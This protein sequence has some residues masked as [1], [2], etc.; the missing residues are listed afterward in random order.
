MA[1]RPGN[2]EGGDV[3]GADVVEVAG[4]TER[5]GGL[6]PTMLGRRADFFQPLAEEE[7]GEGGEESEHDDQPTSLGEVLHLLALPP[8]G[9][10]EKAEAQTI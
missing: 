2:E 7:H 5:L 1:F 3:V 10:S 8:F 9:S 4:D 6:L